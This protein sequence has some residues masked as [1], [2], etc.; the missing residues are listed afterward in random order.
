MAASASEELI[1]LCDELR[2]LQ[3]HALA[4]EGAGEDEISLVA[5][6]RRSAARNLIDYLALRQRDL[7]NLQRALQ[8]HGFSSLGVVQGHVMSSV[9]AVLVVLDELSG[10]AHPPFDL[11]NYPSIEGARDQL[12]AFADETLGGSHGDN[13]VR[14]M[15]TMPSE[16]ASD[17]SVVDSLLEQGMSVMRVNCAHDGPAEWT[18]MIENLRRAE[19]KHRRS[20]RVSFDLAGPKLR[21]GEIQPGDEVLRFKPVRDSMGRVIATGTIAFRPT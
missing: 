13:A 8:R 10:Q 7:V 18:A 17:P 6:S 15:V 19:Q 14:I 12:R 4:V 11:S 2:S 3:Q 16:A 20:C 21:T 5:P 1:A 9:E